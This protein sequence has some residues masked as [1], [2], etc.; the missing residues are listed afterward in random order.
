MVTYCFELV[1]NTVAA[2]FHIFNSL[3]PVFNI[4]SLALTIFLFYCTTRFI[5][6][7]FL[8]SGSDIVTKAAKSDSSKSR[9]QKS[10]E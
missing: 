2:V 10:E 8:Q 1:V 6:L 4:T 9:S 7:P 5:I 3:D